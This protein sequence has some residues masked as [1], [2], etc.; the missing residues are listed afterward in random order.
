MTITH[1]EL[2]SALV[3]PGATIAAQMTATEADLWHG[4]TG[5]AGETTEIL[6]AVVESELTDELLDMD[7]MLEELGDMEFYIEQVRQ[8][9]GISRDDT[10]C[11]SDDS[12]PSNLFDDAAILAVI[13][14]QLLDL[15]K[16]VAIYKKAVEKDA[17]IAVLA[18]LEVAM[19]RLRM[20]TGY[21]RDESL[22]GNIAK[23]S[24]RYAGLT[25]SN[26]AAQVRADKA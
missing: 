15:A 7:N 22:S 21:T 9:L 20:H 3:K 8:N 2:V 4:A 23:L 17:F 16:K 12:G 1:P 10:L 24:V 6:E 13:G 11:M 25:Y 18:R 19:A 26:E 5:A 14:G